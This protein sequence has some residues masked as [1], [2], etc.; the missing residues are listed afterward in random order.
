MMGQT[1]LLILSL[2]ASPASSAEAAYTVEEARVGVRPRGGGQMSHSQDGRH[3]GWATTVEGGQQVNIDGRP[4][5][6]YDGVGHLNFGPDGNRVAYSVRRGERWFVVCDG[7]ESGPYEG[8]DPQLR[9]MPGPGFDDRPIECTGAVRFSPDGSHLAYVALR[10]GKWVFVHDGREQRA[11]DWAH[12]HG[13]SP[14]GQ[15]VVYT[16]RRGYTSV[17]V[18]DGIEHPDRAPMGRVAFSPDGHRWA[19]P[20]IVG[21]RRQFAVIDGEQGPP[22]ESVGPLVFSPDGRRIAFAAILSD[23]VFSADGSRIGYVA[24]RG[25]EQSGIVWSGGKWV[26]VRDGRAGPEF[27]EIGD[28]Q[29]SDDLSKLAYVGRRDGHQWLVV[30]DTEKLR[31]PGLLR[32]MLSSTGECLSYWWKRGE[33]YRIM[34]NG[35]EC[36]PYDLLLAPTLS[37]DGRH[38][39]F[40]VARWKALDG[41]AVS[42]SGPEDG[43]GRYRCAVLLD[44]AEGPECDSICVRDELHFCDDGGLEYLA[45]RDGE[46]YRVRHS[47]TR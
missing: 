26:A 41:K 36:G 43:P 8:I 37:P 14:G 22:R 31:T 34:V 44:G 13:F 29:F 5:P 1:L 6:T 21:G 38:A 10:A 33:K 28:L 12:F 23:P 47:P 40:V 11:C 18:I 24:A 32:V 4:G 30:G 45:A 25:G 27:D 46:L 9:G 42:A 3:V 16:A 35:R 17:T 15:H 19:Y 7:Q 20:G 2:A 39:A